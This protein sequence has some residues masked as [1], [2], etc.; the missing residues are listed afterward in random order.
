MREFA[1]FGDEVDCEMFVLHPAHV[2]DDIVGRRVLHGSCRDVEPFK[3]GFRQL[4][5]KADEP[6]LPLLAGLDSEHDGKS[7]LIGVVGPEPGWQP[8][9]PQPVTP[10]REA[11]S[12]T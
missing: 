4:A 1:S 2:I 10:S 6:D 7:A 3:V 5:V 9:L 8:P 12:V 11:V